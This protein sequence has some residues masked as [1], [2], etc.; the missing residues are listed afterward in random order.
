MNY[1]PSPTIQK[2]NFG[3]INLVLQNLQQSLGGIITMASTNNTEALQALRTTQEVLTWINKYLNQG[4]KW[5]PF[6]LIEGTTELNKLWEILKRMPSVMDMLLNTMTD[7]V[8]VDT[9][10]LIPPL[11]SFLRRAVV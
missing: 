4:N 9:T 5:N 11:L 10:L 1:L 6:S 2:R 7:P 8:K 3:S